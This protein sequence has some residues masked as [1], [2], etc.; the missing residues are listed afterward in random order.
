MPRK[1]YTA[2]ETVTKLGRHPTVF[3]AEQCEGQGLAP[4]SLARR[5]VLQRPR[6]EGVQGSAALAQARNSPEHRLPGMRPAPVCWREAIQAEILLAMLGDTI[7]A[8][9]DQLETSLY[10]AVKRHLERLGFVAKGE[11]CGCDIVALRVASDPFLVIVEMKLSFTLELVLQAVDRLPMADEIWLAVRAS[12]RGRD[13]D[14]R[15][16]KLCRLL[17]FG[18]LRVSASSGKVEVLT[19]PSPYRPRL[20]ERRR[21]RLVDEHQ[22]RQGDPAHGG[23]TRQPIMTAYRQRALA[24]AVRLRDGPQ[25]VRALRSIAED[26]S[27]ILLR[28]VY[29][30]FE[31]ERRGIYRLTP[32]GQAALS[33]WAPSS[34][35]IDEPAVATSL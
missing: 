10:A 4:G 7:R 9:A 22:R 15:V 16:Q 23:S 14:R 29:G 31:R 11:I 20:N 27:A 12:T 5:L 6:A 25:P 26:A 28:N 30:W 8:P 35:A 13:R 34:P 3:S 17:G 18:L 19:E 33:K 32:A 1:R 2:E 21:S 24:C